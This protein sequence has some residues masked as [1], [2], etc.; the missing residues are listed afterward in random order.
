MRPFLAIGGLPQS[1][2]AA[3][4]HIEMALPSVTGHSTRAI[5]ERLR[6]AVPPTD[7]NGP[8]NES[9]ETGQ[10]LG[11]RE[12]GGREAA[13]LPQFPSRDETASV[14]QD[15]AALRSRQTF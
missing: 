9:A 1:A 10:I 7:T 13:P 4:F 12:E 5:T 3:R 11:S 2:G 8:E 15:Q 6:Q 14:G